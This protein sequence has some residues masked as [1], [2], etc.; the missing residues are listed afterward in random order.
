MKL[1]G[2]QMIIYLVVQDTCFVNLPGNYREDV[3]VFHVE[4]DEVADDI[5][6]IAKYFLQF[7][8]KYIDECIFTDEKEANLYALKRSC[9][10][11]ADKYNK[12]K[13]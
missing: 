10:K 13:E 12:V 1:D 6:S 2:A 7:S 5:K 9:D 3:G 4:M 8:E 11:L